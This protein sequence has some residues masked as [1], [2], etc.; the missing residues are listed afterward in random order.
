MEIKRLLL[1]EDS[2]D[3]VFIF[4][5]GVKQTRVEVKID[6]VCNAYDAL[7]LVTRVCP[8]L[9]TLDINLPGTGG[10]ELLRELRNRRALE[11]TPIV[12]MSDTKADSDVELSYMFGA[13]SFVQKP[14]DYEEY[15]NRVGIVLDYWLHSNCVAISD[16]V[17]SAVVR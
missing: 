6:R 3:D 11:R 4:M 9:I 13:N 12:M 1:V 15:I 10:L 2:D 5:R 8:D 16:R 17:L 14:L 7:D